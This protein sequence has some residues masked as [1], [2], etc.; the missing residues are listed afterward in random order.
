MWITNK[1]LDIF[2]VWPDGKGVNWGRWN[3]RIEESKVS[4]RGR[5]IKL[6]IR[7]LM[8]NQKCEKLNILFSFFI[9]SSIAYFIH[10][11]GLQ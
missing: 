1:G 11:L 4:G 10:D 6:V 3:R 2:R 5:W 7:L 9:K 8:T